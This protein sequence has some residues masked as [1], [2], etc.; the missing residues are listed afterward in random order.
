MEIRVNSLMSQNDTA[1]Y[2]KY[3]KIY[4]KI[5]IRLSVR[6]QDT[7]APTTITGQRRLNVIMLWQQKEPK[8]KACCQLLLSPTSCG[9][10]FC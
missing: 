4:F 5:S 2:L 3:F 9:Q 6:S 7:E 10:R 1:L 8:G